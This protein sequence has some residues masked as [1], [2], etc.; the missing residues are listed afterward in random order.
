MARVIADGF[1]RAWGHQV[2][3]INRPGAG[4]FLSVQA[5]ASAKSDGHTLYLGFASAFVSLPEAQPK[6]APD[7]KRLMPIGLVGEQPMVFAVSPKLGVSSMAELLDQAR[8]RPGEMLY[9]GFRATMPHLAGAMLV[10]RSNAVPG[11][12]DAHDTQSAA[13]TLRNAIKPLEFQSGKLA[14]NLARSGIGLGIGGA[15]MARSH[16]NPTKVA[17]GAGLAYALSPYGLSQMALLM[18]NPTLGPIITKLA[19]T[20][21]ALSGGINEPGTGT[22]AQGSAP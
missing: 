3:V 5:A 2:V 17:Q 20:G 6:I 11:L 7:L 4:G 8:K 13:I 14:G 12:K 19:Q 15:V 21:L 9:G 1:T 10:S 16:G 18:G 22:Q